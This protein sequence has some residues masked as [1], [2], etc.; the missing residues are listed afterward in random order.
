V[1][2]FQRFHERDWLF[3]KTPIFFGS[4]ESFFRGER[5]FFRH[6]VSG[7]SQFE[8]RT[9]HFRKLL[10]LIPFMLA[11]K[12][13]TVGVRYW[14][15]SFFWQLVARKCSRSATRREKTWGED[16]LVRKCAGEYNKKNYSQL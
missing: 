13:L 16:P 10:W 15:K 3:T 8:K 14:Q 6:N 11:K 4:C 1:K 12:L 5:H 9:G 2:H 7:Q